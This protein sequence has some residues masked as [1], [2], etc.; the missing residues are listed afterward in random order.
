VLLIIVQMVNLC[1]ISVHN[2]ITY[3][4]IMLMKR[5]KQEHAEMSTL[6]T[7][8]SFPPG[9]RILARIIARC[10]LE[11]KQT[12][13]LQNDRHSTANPIPKGVNDESWQ[14]SKDQSRSDDNEH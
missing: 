5:Q 10:Y 8:D 14:G 1:I 2:Y 3:G 13:H 9:L 4:I 12:Q 6:R 11:K 7:N